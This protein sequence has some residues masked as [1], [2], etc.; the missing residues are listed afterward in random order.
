MQD[1]ITVPVRDREHERILG[2]VFDISPSQAAIVSCLSR[3][4]TVTGQELLD[5]GDA[6]SQ[7]RV[8]ISRTRSKLKAYGIDINAKQDVGYWISADDK[9]TIEKMVAKFLGR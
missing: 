2:I 6:T 4:T 5:Y 7:V 8:I 1:T 3:S 9:R